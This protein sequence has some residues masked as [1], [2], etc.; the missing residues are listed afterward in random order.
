MTEKL[1]I[2]L[3]LP[4]GS[5]LVST[6]INGQDYA[7]LQ[8][9]PQQGQTAKYKVKMSHLSSIGLIEVIYP[10][11]EAV[12]DVSEDKVV[13][14]RVNGEPE[15]TVN[16]R[17]NDRI[18]VGVPD[19]SVHFAREGRFLL[20]EGGS[21][22]GGRLES[23]LS[24][25]LLRKG[26]A[27]GETW[28][29]RQGENADTGARKAE[30]IYTYHG[31][32]NYYG[33][34][35]HRVDVRIEEAAGSNP[36]TATGT[37]WLSPSDGHRLGEVYFLKNADLGMGPMRL[38]LVRE[39]ALGS[40]EHSTAFWVGRWKGEIETATRDV[41]EVWLDLKVDP[42]GKPSLAVDLVATESPFGRATRTD[43]GPRF[44]SGDLLWNLDLL[45]QKYECRTRFGDFMSADSHC[46]TED[47]VLSLLLERTLDGPWVPADLK[48]IAGNDG[49]RAFA[50]AFRQAVLAVAGNDYDR[51]D[52]LFVDNP[53][54]MQPNEL[55]R[56][57]SRVLA[58]FGKI[59]SIEFSKLDPPGAYLKVSFDRAEREFFL[60]LDDSGKLSELTYVPPSTPHE[61]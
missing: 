43:T 57:A 51:F 30:F 24:V 8:W 11:T 15:V 27:Y 25:V 39:P 37:I 13:L 16:G 58:Q 9:K 61:H 10:S 41:I 18:R 46:R 3:S 14:K 34:N 5:G 6:S 33:T 31:R 42:A 23:L 4:L 47:S 19:R 56:S 50:E 38:K 7:T 59:R 49:D 28:V 48:V 52:Q 54:G 36:V 55:W 44:E 17:P 1:S 53:K 35:A 32:E 12:T 2:L 29:Y 20:S 21:T 26:V 60:Q 45:G 22:T 40:V